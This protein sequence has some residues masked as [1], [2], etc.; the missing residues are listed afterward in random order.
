M[1]DLTPPP[2]GFDMRGFA[3]FRERFQQQLFAG[4]PAQVER[5]SWPAAA[6][7]AEQEAALR[8]LLAHAV[9]HARFYRERLGG[10]DPARFRL[11]D[12]P[13]LPVLRKAEMM[14]RFDDLTTRPGLTR[15]RL[16]IALAATSTGPVVID[17]ELVCLTSGGSSGERGLFAFDVDAMVGFASSIMRPTVA[18]L[19]SLASGPEPPLI[20]MIGASS[21]VH[22]TGLATRLLDS[23]PVEFRALPVTL[24]IERIVA[25]L[26]EL[27]PPAVFGYPSVLVQLAR[28]QQA[29]R[30]RI[31]PRSLTSTS[32]TLV[33]TWRLLIRDAFGAPIVNTFA[34]TE[35]LV[36][37]SAPD[38]E[39]VTF[40]TDLCIVEPVDDQHRPVPLGVPAAKVLITNLFNLVQPLIRYELADRIVPRSSAGFLVAEVEGRTDDVLRYGHTV[41]HPHVIRSVLLRHPDVL[42]H[43]IRQT[44]NGVDV[45]L[46]AR[47]LS[48]GSGLVVIQREIE[49]A[50][51]AGGLR[52]PDVTV[53]P[54]AHVERDARTGKARRVVPLAA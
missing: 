33:P 36:G 7:V 27:Q 50:L 21:P 24:P 49:A 38:G 35:G 1:R 6:V 15:E 2:G 48:P 51:V 10:I 5:L 40:A 54:V 52:H 34:S 28:E 23:G 14:E 3:H 30:L 11:T 17:G 42:D 19:G 22:A 37:S 12:L 47:D 25:E 29:G 43:Q 44:P 41:I 4:M 31:R 16:E 20:A 46:V 45:L 8:R 9:G 13:G 32:E 26:N 39:T 53:S 18:R